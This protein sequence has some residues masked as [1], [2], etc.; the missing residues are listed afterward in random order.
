VDD[1][2]TFVPAGTTVVMYSDFDMNLATPN[3]LV[4]IVNGRFANPRESVTGPAAIANYQLFT[5]DDG[6]VARWLALGGE[7]GVPIRFVG[8]DPQLPDQVRLCGDPDACAAAGSH[9]CNGVLA[10]V[11]DSQ[12][13]LLACRGYVGDADGGMNMEFGSDADDPLSGVTSEMGQWI[14]GFLGRAKADPA[15]AAREFDAL[16]QGTLA[17]V[18]TFP[19]LTRWVEARST[20]DYATAGDVDQAVGQLQSSGGLAE[21]VT[22]LDEVPAYG[23]AVAALARSQPEAFGRATMARPTVGNALAGS[24]QVQQAYFVAIGRTI[25]ADQGD[26]A[27][28]DWY[29]QL[30]PDWRTAMRRDDGLRQASERL[31]MDAPSAPT[32]RPVTIADVDWGVVQA[33]NERL[34]KDSDEG[35]S[36]PYWQRGAQVIIGDQQSAAWRRAVEAANG[37]DPADG[38]SPTGTITMAE[39]GGTFSRGTLRVTGSTDAAGMRTAIAAFSN[40]T[41][42]FA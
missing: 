34:L 24:A 20:A 31:G 37:V 41:V 21:V 40:K 35:E 10:K 3:A 16:P 14:S 18:S 4:A 28:A 39:K 2:E 8:I 17:L 22:W 13:V 9:Q 23:Q 38:S 26:T 12:I 11:V 6:F 42:E 29:R 1:V 5:Q 15:A 36:F 7:G 30:S 19:A 27:F 25:L 33:M 32:A